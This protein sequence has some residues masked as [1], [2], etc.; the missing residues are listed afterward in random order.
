MNPDEL[1][2]RLNAAVEPVE[3]PPAS[4]GRLKTNIARRR[5]LALG[6][7]AGVAAAA[8]A[9]VAV[10]AA[11]ALPRH[12]T[13]GVTAP[14]GTPTDQPSD[15]P[16]AS[17]TAAPATPT[18]T[19]PATGPA[20]AAA[21]G[22]PDGNVV[23][24][25]STASGDVDGDGRFD[26]VSLVHPPVPQTSPRW[27]WGVRAALSR[28]GT[29]TVWQ[30]Y[31]TD[32]N[33]AQA[34]G[35]VEDMNGDGYAEI[36]ASG[37]GTAFGRSFELAVVVGG[38]L[39]WVTNGAQHAFFRSE[40]RP[41]HTDSGFGC[42]ELAAASPGREL[43]QVDTASTDGGATWQGTRTLY[44]LNGSRLERVGTQTKTWHGAAAP[45]GYR[46]GVYCG[47]LR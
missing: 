13:S 27:R 25:G 15:R 8:V 35:G 39:A 34:L 5:R 26:T 17:L 45:A 43:Y 10:T 44:R 14:T 29:Q 11:V 33:E 30:P 4:Y 47:S 7:Y 31:G 12:E 9:A 36:V 2:T 20:T 32:S 28:Y 18:A 21:T 3:A 46:P 6:T 41:D 16:T 42:A 24:F 37:G 1:R 40:Q 19:G 22:G 23:A 38:R